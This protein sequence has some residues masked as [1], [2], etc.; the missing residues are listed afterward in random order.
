MK[1]FIFLLLSILTLSTVSAQS[2][3][4]RFATSR[5]QDN[6][7]RVLTV[8]ASTITPVTATVTIPALTKYNNFVSVASTSLSPTFTA[9][10]TSSYYG[11][12]MNLFVKA[13]ATGTRTVTLG[14]NLIGTASTAT[15]AASKKALFIFVFD[16]AKWVESSR[17]VE[18]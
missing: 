12:Q 9:N 3:S 18:P 14:A 15:V 7:Y 16:G 11:D 2:T 6:T 1:K 10:V 8:G 13:D 5:T 17:C 4:T